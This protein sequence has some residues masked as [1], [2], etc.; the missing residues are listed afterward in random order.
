MNDQT[1]Q[2]MI[3]LADDDQFI[4]HAYKTGLEEAGYVVIVASDGEQALTQ[5]RALRPNLLLMELILPKLDGFS[6]LKTVKEDPTI[7]DVA[8][9]I[10]TNLAQQSDM[11]EALKLGAI[12]VLVKPDVS[13]TDVLARIDRLLPR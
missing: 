1:A 12:D 5:V 3:V 10:L 6:V 8:I 4:T 13:L 7:A 9:M 11:E 2:R